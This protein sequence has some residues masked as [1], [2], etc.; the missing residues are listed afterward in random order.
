[1]CEKLAPEML[2][3][4]KRSWKAQKKKALRKRSRWRRREEEESSSH[5]NWQE[6]GKRHSLAS[7][8]VLPLQALDS[9]KA[10]TKAKEGSEK[11]VT[12]RDC[13]SWANLKKGGKATN[14]REREEK[15]WK[16]WR[17]FYS[18]GR[19]EKE[20]FSGIFPYRKISPFLPSSTQC[21]S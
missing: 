21:Q 10:A 3:Q 16:S 2:P 4:K 20:A 7:S 9:V 11:K 5:G 13:Q 17:S 1:M 15:S 19:A 6:V 14:E 18:L 8:V 12:L